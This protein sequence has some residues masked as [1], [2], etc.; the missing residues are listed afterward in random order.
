MSAKSK[1]ELAAR[2]DDVFLKVT[3]S[4]GV[5]DLVNVAK[6][7]WPLLDNKVSIVDLAGVYTMSVS[8]S[9]AETLDL[10]TFGDFF[11]GIARVKF[12]SG[13]N[14]SERLLE[15]LGR[16]HEVKIRSDL[17]VFEQIMDKLV[18]KVLLKYDLPLRR[19]FSSFAGQSINIGGGMTW[20]E[21]VKLGVGMEVS[22]FT[23]FAGAY[24]LIPNILSLHKCETLARDTMS[25]FPV[26]GASSSQNSAML[27]PQYQLLLCFV[28]AEALAARSKSLG[29]SK[30]ATKR[31]DAD[32]KPMDQMLSDLIRD[33][34]IDRSVNKPVEG[35]MMLESL[36][37]P[38]RSIPRGRSGDMGDSRAGSTISMPGTVVLPSQNRPENQ[39]TGTLSH[40][41]HAQLMRMENL[42]E[43]IESKV[44]GMLDPGSDILAMMSLPNDIV[45]AKSRLTSKPVVIGDAVP[46][47]AICPEPVEQLLQASLAHHNLG[48]FEEALKFIEAARMQ[49]E[50]FS[51]KAATA[52]KM[53]ETG[54]GG[55]P[56]GS[57]D[58]EEAEEKKEA[59]GE[60]VGAAATTNASEELEDGDEDSPSR[61]EIPLDIDMYI[62][63]C[64][65]NVY[66]SCGDDEQSMLHYLDGLDRAKESND[67]DWEI[68]CLN[69]IGMLA[70]YSLR[71]DVALLCFAAVAAYRNGAYGADSADTATAVN[72]E[73]CCLYCMNQKGEARLRFE[74]A[75]STMCKVLGHRAPRSVTS[76]K[77]LEKARRAHAA[78]KDTAAT[79]AMRPDIDNLLTGGNIVI[80]ALGPPVEGGKKKGGK[81]GKKGK[82]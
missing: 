66:Q 56:K 15:E 10:I 73:A 70:Y 30:F 47:P 6:V 69:S 57:D 78:I 72:N 20:E 2:I 16:A 79:V 62:T 68:V 77:N 28:A 24:S 27:Y 46:V 5:A 58:E 50:D 23:S 35:D 59:S 32:N 76:W 52:R 42:F 67:K 55:E 3:S 41:R 54:D 26:L 8:G 33:L 61:D 75:W 43:E 74:K 44:L 14:F 60:A 51:M 18:V 7:F 37:S 48:S 64:K 25:R 1:S 49:L 38:S 17:P 13:A 65:G 40:S 19:A 34:G 11:H 80:N 12:S 39:Y 9:D 63:L 82:K 53:T 81:K 21:V 22:G 36:N 45:D 71:Y 31:F 4:T 29:S